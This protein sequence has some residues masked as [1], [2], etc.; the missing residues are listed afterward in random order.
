VK[1]LNPI[2][3]KLLEDEVTA[4][5]TAIT[6]LEERIAVA[7]AKLGVFTSAE[8]SQKASAEVE[9]LRGEHAKLQARW[10]ELGM[11]LEEQS[12]AV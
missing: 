2:K 12:A 10:E 8:E 11:Q 9:R 4:T 3:L 7:E 1:K 5:E 6:E